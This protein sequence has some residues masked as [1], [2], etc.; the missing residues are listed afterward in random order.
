MNYPFRVS[1]LEY[2]RGGDAAAFREAMETIRENYPRSAFYSGMNMLGT[3]DTPRVLT[4]LGTCPKEA[5]ATRTER[6]HYR[7]GVHGQRRGPGQVQA[8]RLGP[9]VDGGHGGLP[10]LVNAA[11]RPG[12]SAGSTPRVPSWPL[13]GTRRGRPPW[14]PSTR[15]PRRCA[16]T[17]WSGASPGCRCTG[18]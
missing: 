9:R 3:H 4:M 12:I 13:P 2:L 16:W 11:S 14:P 10:L 1:A 15:G 17:C 18:T 8:H 7:E 5:P 6:A